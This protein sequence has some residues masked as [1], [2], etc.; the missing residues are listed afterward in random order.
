LLDRIIKLLG[1]SLG[2]LLVFLVGHLLS[3]EREEARA[4]A[5]APASGQMAAPASRVEA[6][7]GKLDPTGVDLPTRR[8]KTFPVRP[9]DSSP[10]MQSR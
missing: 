10:A 9:D 1:L 3:F 6:E 4:P 2:A 7:A 8:V 5:S